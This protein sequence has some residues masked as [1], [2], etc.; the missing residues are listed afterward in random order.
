VEIANAAMVN[1][2]H[3]IS[4]QRGYDPREFVLVGF[5]G[6]GPLHAN[7]LARDSE[8]PTLV[9]P[10]APGIFSATGLVG[11]DLKRD[12]SV[13]LLRRLEE[14]DDAEVERVFAELEAAGSQ[15][16]AAEGMAAERMVFVRQ[17]DMRYVGQS[18]EL[19]IPLEGAAFDAGQAAALGE[20]FHTEHAR[21]YGFSAPKEPVEVVNLRLTAVGRIE[22]PAPR[23]L[24]PG[25]RRPE[26]K[27]HRQV[28]FA[29]QDGFVDCPIHERYALGAGATLAGPVV[30]EE[31]D[32]TVV[33]HPGYGVEV[34]AVGNLVIRKDGG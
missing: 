22:K 32:S 8:M 28:F 18:F 4:V 7:A 33:V 13:T 14:L 11:T 31:L 6:A 16:L 20:R 5:G 1:A 3:L 24:A 29:E 10:V 27:A 9:V 17:I 2:L 12:S 19:T 23:P 15:E 25:G 21:V 26:P 30:I 34:D